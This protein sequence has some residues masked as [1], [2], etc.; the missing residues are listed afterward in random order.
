[1]FNS[2]VSLADIAAVTGRR[3]NDGF[4]DGGG[5]WAWIILFALFGG[6]WGGNGWGNNGANAGTQAIEAALQRGLNNQGVVQKLDGISNGICSLG[7]D[8]LNQMNGINMNVMQTAFGLQQAI[9]GVGRQV[10]DCCC[11]TQSGLK[12]I[13]YTIATEGCATRQQVHETGDQIQHALNW[14]LRDLGDKMQQGFDALE[15][16]ATNRYIAELERKVNTCDRDTALQ[17]WANYVVNTI[18]PRTQPAYLTCN[19][20]TGMVF[21]NMQQNPIPVQF[22]NDCGCNTCCNRC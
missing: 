4:G 14:G 21:P 20:N 10:E 18:S 2:G 16:Q 5:W 22:N 1:M 19:P 6:G 9:N 12:D 7:Y 13:Q 17:G 3:D 15:K 8:Q 11:K